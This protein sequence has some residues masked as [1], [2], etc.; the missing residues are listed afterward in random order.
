MVN[1]MAAAHALAILDAFLLG[2]LTYFGLAFDLGQ[3]GMRTW[4]LDEASINEASNINI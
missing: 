2:N 4:A 1:H 3:G